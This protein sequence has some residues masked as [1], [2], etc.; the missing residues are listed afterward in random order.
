MAHDAAERDE[1]SD[2]AEGD[3]ELTVCGGD[4][5]A[6]LPFVRVERRAAVAADGQQ[7]GHYTG[8]DQGRANPH[9]NLTPLHQRSVT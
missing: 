7:A 1:Q 8:S 9:Q 6:R 2:N 5:V 3:R 4:K